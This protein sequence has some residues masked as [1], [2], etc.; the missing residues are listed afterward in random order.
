MLPTNE[1]TRRW[2]VAE[3]KW[4]REG[5][6]RRLCLRVLFRAEIALIV[7]AFAPHAA[8]VVLAIGRGV[9]RGAVLAGGIV[10]RS[11]RCGNGRG[12]LLGGLGARFAFGRM[13]RGASKCG[14]P[15]DASKEEGRRAK[16]SAA[17]KPEAK[18]RP[19]PRSERRSLLRRSL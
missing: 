10:R 4:R 7:D 2:R 19:A 17:M 16:E 15:H 18:K 3:K 13:T 5:D 12:R 14:V 8:L 9:R 11:V 1:N 6:A